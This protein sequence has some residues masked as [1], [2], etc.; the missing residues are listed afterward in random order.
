MKSNAMLFAVA[1]LL[2]FT[3]SCRNNIHEKENWGSIFQKRGIDSACFEMYDNTHDQA[4]Y[5]NKARCSQRVSPASTF[6]IVNSLIG[7]ETNLAP[8]IEWVIQWDGIERWNKNWNQDLNMKQAFEYSAVP[9]YQAL[10]R[11]IGRDTMQHYLDTLRYGN[12]T[13]GDSLDQFWL[14]GSLKVTPDEQV[15]FLKRLYFDKHPLSKRSQRLVR[16]LMLREKNDDY[17]LSY[18]TGTMPTATGY[19]CQLVGY[20]EKVESQK[21]V[22]SGNDETNYRPYFFAMS[23][24]TQTKEIDFDEN[25]KERVAIV[26]DIFRDLEIIN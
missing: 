11:K 9:Y 7:L 19:N 13:I 4:F 24:D 5:Y 26:K 8:D 16:T 3:A 12:K 10:A 6:K 25:I 22:E 20:L 23:F 2:L 18:K 17:K 15:G 14:D 1:A 21:N